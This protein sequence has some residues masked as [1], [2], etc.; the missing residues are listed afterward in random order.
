MF[1]YSIASNTKPEIIVR[2]LN[3]KNIVTAA[4]KNN[5]VVRNIG[6]ILIMVLI[7]RRLF[8]LFYFRR[9]IAG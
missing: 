5:R 2:R 7:L 4:S 6:R 1:P 8:F 3:L 9:V